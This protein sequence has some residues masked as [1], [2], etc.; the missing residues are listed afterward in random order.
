MSTSNI[1]AARDLTTEEQVLH[2]HAAIIKRD[3]EA[4]RTS[5]P[6]DKAGWKDKIVRHLV[7]DYQNLLLQAE[8]GFI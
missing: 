7:L 2:H 5:R 8:L 4:Y 3:L 6:R 1:N